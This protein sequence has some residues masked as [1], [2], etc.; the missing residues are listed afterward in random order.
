MLCVEHEN[1]TDARVLDRNSQYSNFRA[2]CSR[3]NT[4]LFENNSAPID[5]RQ[6]RQVI[7]T[8]KCT[9]ILNEPAWAVI[10]WRDN[11]S[12]GLLMPAH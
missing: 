10:W 6:S 7:V 2:F 9:C 11:S 1:L 3:S 8:K 4:S 12:N 5:P